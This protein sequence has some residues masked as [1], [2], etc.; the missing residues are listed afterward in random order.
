M[1]IINGERIQQIADIYLGSPGDF[2]YNPI[3]FEQI[4]K[5]MVLE[6]IDA[7]FDNPYIM[8]LYPHLLSTFVQKLR[9]FKN[10]FTLITHN[11]DTNLE[12]SD[13]NVLAI[14]DCSKLVVWWG[15]N[16]CFVHPKMRILPIGMANTMWDHGKIEIFENIDCTKCHDVYFNFNVYTNIEKRQPCADAF[17][18]K[19]EFLSMTSPVEN[20]KRLAKYKWCICPE[21]NGV[22]THRL[23]EAMYLKCVPIVLR[24]P[25]IE[26]LIHYTGGEL[27]I[28]VVD[29]WNDL[30][31]LDYNKFNFES[32]W[33]KL[34]QWISEIKK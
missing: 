22:D 30:S 27:P 7:D 26:T 21:G 23:W 32:K 2:I 33:L 14:L 19:Y 16:L 12:Y 8:F 28:C 13:P 9:F 1:E 5:H 31:L 18:D 3:I 10:P 24:S 29:S 25:F 4:E 17:Y 11:S 15:Q 20:I 6:H 34:E